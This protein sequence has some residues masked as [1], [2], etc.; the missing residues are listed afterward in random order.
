ML[1]KVPHQAKA[2]KESVERHDDRRAFYRVDFPEPDE[3]ICHESGVQE[4][5]GLI[6]T[7]ILAPPA[8]EVLYRIVKD[9]ATEEEAKNRH[10]YRRAFRVVDLPEPDE[11]EGP[12]HDLGRIEISEHGAHVGDGCFLGVYLGDRCRTWIAWML[13]LAV[14]GSLRVAPARVTVG[15]SRVAIGLVFGSIWFVV[16][17][18]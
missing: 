4:K 12:E 17:K 11:V 18:G 7:R 6:A 15:S 10:R 1:N 13:V 16:S 8:R 14:V 2:E 9:A 5:R 3:Q